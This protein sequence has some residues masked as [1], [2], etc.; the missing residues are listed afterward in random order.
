[1]VTS[2]L[3]DTAGPARTQMSVPTRTPVPT[4]AATPRPLP[5]PARSVL[6]GLSAGFVLCALIPGYLVLS[7]LGPDQVQPERGIVLW[8]QVG[9]TV[10][11]GAR[12]TGLLAVGSLR[13]LGYFFWAYVYIW[14]G[15]AGIA[16]I[17]TGRSPVP[18]RGETVYLTSAQVI[19]MVGL[20]GYAV[21]GRLAGTPRTAGRRPA[22][23]LRP[24]RGYL[25]AA[26]AF[27]AIC[28]ALV[29]RIGGLHAVFTSR[30]ARSLAL[31]VHGLIEQNDKASGTLLVSVATV[32]AFLLLYGLLWKASL[33]SRLSVAEL[34]VL[35][36]LLVVNV[37][38]NNPISSAR[39]W[40]GTVVVSALLL[41][42]GLHRAWAARALMAAMVLGLLLAFPY[43]DRYR[44][45]DPQDRAAHSP[46]EELVRKGD[47]DSFPQIR[48]A[49]E[50]VG[51]NG[52]TGG[53]QLEGMLLFW[54][55]RHDWP[56]KPM[57]TGIVLAGFEGDSVNSNLS[58]PLW[59]ESYLDFGLPGV[60]V[61]FLALG[62]ASRRADDA[63]V[64]DF[65][66]RRPTA[67]C[68]AVPILAVYQ[69][70]VLRGSLL[71]SMFRLSVIVLLL[72][73]L[74]RP[75]DRKGHGDA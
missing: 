4:Q 49:A 45:T 17:A 64:R 31:H 36:V 70:I 18:L 1:M 63:F 2:A 71:Q 39:H 52:H 23:R 10:I 50:Y 34:G 67:A 54:V 75:A 60:L 25:V 61:T 21:G 7:G 6:V 20:V 5:E 57:D 28:P 9:V 3:L 62:V 72:Y 65:W 58:A 51:A 11:A 43:A 66:H 19:I 33:I 12:L 55:P 59:A 14:L 16:Q 26:L 41:V 24:A 38:V 29:A 69:M 27:V 35:V 22:R 56:D 37:V 32:T 48:A 73:C 74:F 8:I 15:V 40:F 68:L 47:Y 13:P 53:R 46:A 44:Y 42:R 30:E